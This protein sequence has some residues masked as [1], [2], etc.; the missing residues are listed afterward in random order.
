MSMSSA[1]IEDVCVI[2]SGKLNRNHCVIMW[3][4]PDGAWAE[5]DRPDALDFP[6]LIHNKY[7]YPHTLPQIPHTYSTECHRI[8]AFVSNG[9]GHGPR[10]RHYPG[11]FLRYKG[12]TSRSESGGGGVKFF[13]QSVGNLSRSLMV[14]KFRDSSFRSYKEPLSVR[15]CEWKISNVFLISRIFFRLY[16]VFDFLHFDSHAWLSGSRKV[17]SG[18]TSLFF[19]MYHLL[20]LYTFFVGC[21][22]FFDIVCI[23]GHCRIGHVAP[24]S[25]ALETWSDELPDII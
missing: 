24:N 11:R 25:Q 7:I 20:F 3:C 23:C 5:R 19:Y 17:T 8:S 1:L 12:P 22:V 13:P 9:R 6:S 15:S 10:S 14:M 21:V 18:S 2:P 4:S 16:V